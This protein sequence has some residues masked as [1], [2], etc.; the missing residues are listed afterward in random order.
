MQTS[1]TFSIH[2]WLS[3]AKKKDD[4]APLYARITV[5]GKRAEISLKRYLSVTYWDPIAKRAKPRTPNAT[6]LNAYLDQ[7][8]ADLLEC[9]KQ[10]LSEF[11]L[12][13]A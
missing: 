7:V 12:V 8:Y 3:A 10:L 13:T 6:A 4:I 2:F 11:K 9:Q 1:K 5:N